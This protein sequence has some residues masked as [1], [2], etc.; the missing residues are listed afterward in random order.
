MQNEGREKDLPGGE[1]S[2]LFTKRFWCPM[3][4]Y[5]MSLLESP[6]GLTPLEPATPTQSGENKKS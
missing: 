4:Q 3:L 2:E 6:S 5:P 1:D